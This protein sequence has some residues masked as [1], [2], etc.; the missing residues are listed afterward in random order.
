MSLLTKSS[1]NS[2]PA[3]ASLCPVATEETHSDFAVIPQNPR[4]SA[5]PSVRFCENPGS[6]S[7][8]DYLESSRFLSK[9]V[10]YPANKTIAWNS[11]WNPVVD[12]VY[13]L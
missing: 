12:K 5:V 7:S 9:A 2:P 13:V 8:G 11:C 1:D 10:L 6:E 3:A 4:A